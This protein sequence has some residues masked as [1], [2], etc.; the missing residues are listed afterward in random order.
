MNASS[1]IMKNGPFPTICKQ[2]FKK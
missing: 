2:L 1:K